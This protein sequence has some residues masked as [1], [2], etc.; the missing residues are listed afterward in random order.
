MRTQ[1]SALLL[2]ALTAPATA[3]AQD[4]DAHGFSMAPQDGDVRDLIS[5]Y[6]PGRMHFKEWYVTGL[7]EYARAPLTLVTVPGDGSDPYDSVYLDHLVALNIGGGFAVHDRV[8]IDARLPLYFASFGVDGNYQGVDLGVMRVSVMASI[9]RP[10]PLSEKATERIGLGIV[11]W[12]DLPTGTQQYLNTGLVSGGGKL[13]GTFTSGAWTVS[14]DAGIQ[15]N[16]AVDLYNITGADTLLAGLGV[17]YLIKDNLGVNVEG[18][19]QAP[20]AAN[21]QAGTATPAEMLLSVRNRLDNGGHWLAGASVGLSQGVGA[22]QF[23]LFAGGGFGKITPAAPIIVDM[24]GDGI[25][26]EVDTCPEQPETF[27]QYRD[28]DGCPDALSGVAVRAVVG[29]DTVEGA[30]IVLSGGPDGDTTHQSGTEPVVV[31]DLMPGT[32]MSATASLGSCLEGSGAAITE[33]GR[34]VP[35]MVRLEPKLDARLVVMVRDQDN[36]PIPTATL[37]W[38]GEDASCLPEGDFQVDDKG[39][40][41]QDVGAGSHQL[42]ATAPGY[43]THIEDVTLNS[44]E[45][46]TVQV[47]LKSSKVRVEKKQIVIL[48]KVYFETAKA[49]IK[50]ESFDLLDEV[51]AIIRA[52]PQV[53]RV[54]IAGHTDSQGGDQYNLE[55]SDDRAKSVRDYLVNK[56][57]KSERLVPK[58]Y[59][60]TKPIESNRTRSGRAANRRVEFNLIDQSDDTIET[61]AE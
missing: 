11:P 30:T 40:G 21:T 22:A 12:I 15:F 6:R 20:L 33:E 13:A 17:G 38:Q 14:A 51:A 9:L 60:E 31:A 8:R 50:P 41:A 19:V 37:R 61:P 46:L 26:D 52:N 35:L 16:P 7:L 27:N 39:D 23:R 49:V 24:D 1:R 57:V 45:S 47:V 29:E 32:N 5:V 55:L 53:G 59:G 28:E 54:E 25:L 3:M 58:G 18:V 56:G 44:G 42:I 48:E 10:H 43:S 34:E 2:L 36:K 4:I